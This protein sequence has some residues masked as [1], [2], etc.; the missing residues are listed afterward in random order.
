MNLLT[1]QTFVSRDVVFHEHIFPHHPSSLQQYKY[2]I[3]PVFLQVPLIHVNSHNDDV[4]CSLEDE[5]VLATADISADH[6]VDHPIEASPDHLAD[7]PIEASPSPHVVPPTSLL[8]AMVPLE[9]FFKS[10]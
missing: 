1:N 3:P 9:N 8:P 4:N 5:Q 6:S 7:Q 2:P 10:H